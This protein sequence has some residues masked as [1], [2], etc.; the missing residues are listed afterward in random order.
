VHALPPLLTRT[1]AVVDVVIV[2]LGDERRGWRTT[3]VNNASFCELR[4]RGVHSYDC[5]PVSACAVCSL[6]VVVMRRSMRS[7]S[8]RAGRCKPSLTTA[9][10]LRRRCATMRGWSYLWAHRTAATRNSH[11][12]PV[13]SSPLT[14]FTRN[15]VVTAL[16]HNV[17]RGCCDDRWST[18]IPKPSLLI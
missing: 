2:D 9:R 4:G 6:A 3:E 11:H 16:Q 7:F 17:R 8:T 1:P 13:L 10:L 5:V 14:S 18:R 15:E 12:R